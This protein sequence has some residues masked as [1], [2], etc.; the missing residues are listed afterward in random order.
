[1]K[2][3]AMIAAALFLI[4]LALW[5]RHHKPRSAEHPSLG[6]GGSPAAVA[7]AAPVNPVRDAY[8]VPTKVRKISREQRG[9][10]AAAIARARNSETAAPAIANAVSPA[11]EPI[12]DVTLVKTTIRDAMRQVT[13][14]LAGCY[15]AEGSAAPKRIRVV[16]AL[17]LT[18]DP[19]VGTVIDA[20]RL[21]DEREAPLAPSFDACLRDVFAAL[22]MPPLSESGQVDVTYPFVFAA[23]EHD[24]AGE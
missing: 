14:F 1:M 21:V 19:E 2:R 9:L 12:D 18:G 7:G 23:S 13:P 15:D 5:R 22:E 10:L 6:A 11:S 24:A 4:A 17:T 20:Q 16:A 3:P 8:P